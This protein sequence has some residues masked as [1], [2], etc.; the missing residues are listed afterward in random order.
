MK[1]GKPFVPSSCHGYLPEPPIFNLSCKQAR[2]FCDRGS[3][4]TLCRQ[5]TRPCTRPPDLRPARSCIARRSSHKHDEEY[6]PRLK[7]THE[8]KKYRRIKV[9]EEVLPER[10]ECKGFPEVWAD[11]RQE[12]CEGVPYF[13][14][15]QGG[16]YYRHDVAFGY[17]I[18]AFTAERDY[19]G[20]HVV[21]S[22]GYRPFSLTDPHF[23][24]TWA[25]CMA[26]CGGA[27]GRGGRSQVDPTTQVRALGGSQLSSDRGVSALLSNYRNQIPLVLIIG[28]KCRVSPVPFLLLPPSCSIPFSYIVV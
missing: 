22:H 25:V 28:D 16:I 4:C 10:P 21:I 19:I 11:T 5:H 9:E 18:D 27:D 26:L 14:A 7:D 12:L 13:R 8:R 6:E 23:F 15:Y 3:P 20:S 2:L 17:L 1:E 24:W